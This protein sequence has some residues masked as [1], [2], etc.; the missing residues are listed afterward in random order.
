MSSST[1]L[2]IEIWSRCEVNI[3]LLSNEL[4]FNLNLV[5][6]KHPQNKDEIKEE[7][8]LLYKV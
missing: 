1:E 4:F 7:L 5:L 6:G 3:I 8:G 2:L